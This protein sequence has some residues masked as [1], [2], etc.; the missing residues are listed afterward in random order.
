MPPRND[1]KSPQ[2]DGTYIE[3][4]NQWT[5]RDSKVPPPVQ[6]APN[7]AAHNPYS[8]PVQPYVPPQ[9][10]FACPYC[11]TT[12]PPVWKS[13]VS[14]SGWIVFAILLITTCFFCWVGLLMRN[15]YRVCSQCK[16]RLD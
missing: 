7:Y 12:Q 16:V 15:N 6:A 9:Q 5:E 4:Q 14:Q 13:E 1:S 10:G 3:P 2:H 11:R 8:N